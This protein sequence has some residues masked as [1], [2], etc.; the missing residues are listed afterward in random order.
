[1]QSAYYVYKCLLFFFHNFKKNPKHR[2]LIMLHLNTQ[3]IT[4]GNTDLGCVHQRII[5]PKFIG[6]ESV[7]TGWNVWMFHCKMC[8]AQG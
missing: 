6:H 4:K 3:E 1:M 2:I 8:V 7:R 5:A